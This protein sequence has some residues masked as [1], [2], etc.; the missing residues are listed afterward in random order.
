MAGITAAQSK[1][2]AEVGVASGMSTVL[3]V[4]GVIIEEAP[5]PINTDFDG[6]RFLDDDSREFLINNVR[7]NVERLRA[8]AE[9]AD[10]A[11][12]AY[13]IGASL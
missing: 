8:F 13:E 12:C 3:A 10:A 4:I 11:L 2:V 7:K 5:E 1:I 9:R 6:F